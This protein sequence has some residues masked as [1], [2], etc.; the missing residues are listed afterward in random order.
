MPYPPQFKPQF[1]ELAG[2]V[3]GEPTIAL[4]LRPKRVILVQLEI[5]LT[6]VEW[7]LARW[8]WHGLQG[9]PRQVRANEFGQALGRADLGLGRELL[10]QRV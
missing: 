9:Q 4:D 6:C 10:L 7:N 3:Q 8:H 2:D 1:R 5:H